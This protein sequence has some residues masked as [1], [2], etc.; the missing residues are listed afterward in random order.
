MKAKTREQLITEIVQL[1]ARVTMLEQSL[2]R[3]ETDHAESKESEKRYRTVFDNTGAGTFVK[4]AD[5]TI[6]MVNQEFEGLTGYTKKA[7]EGRMKW[8][9]FFHP[10]D[11]PRLIMYHA[12][13]RKDQSAPKE[14]ECRISQRTGVIKEVFLKLDLIPGTGQTIGSIVDLSPLKQAQ[15]EIDESRA[16][17]KAIVEGFE[18]LLYVCDA[19]FRLA[20]VNPQGR[21]LAG[22]SAAGE[23][24]YQA[25]H[26]RDAPCLFC[27]QDQVLSGQTVR[28]EMINPKDRRW[29][30]STNSPIHHMDGSVSLLAMVT[31]INDRKQA[32]AALRAAEIQT[33]NENIFLRSRISKRHRLGK[34]VGKSPAMQKVYEQIISAAASD[35]TVIIYGEPGTGKELVAR[36]IH[37][38]SDRQSHQFVPVHCGAIPENLIE[39]EFFGYKKGAFSGADSDRAGYFDFADN[40]TMFLDEIGEI[41]LHM[42]VKLLRV[43]EGTGFTPMGS[44]QVKYPN[45]RIISATN[46]DLHQRIANRRMREDFYYRIHIL[47]IQLPP[48]RERKADLPLLIDHFFKIYGGKQTPPPLTRKMMNRLTQYHWP[49]NI[50]ELQNVIIRYCSLQVLELGSVVPDLLSLNSDTPD[51]NEEERSEQARDLKSLLAVHERRL[52]VQALDQNQW[53]RGKAAEHLKIDRKTLFS[54]MKRYGLR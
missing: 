16:L 20:Y 23:I 40:G 1:H 33:R 45:V 52:I 11:R 6:S 39:S 51:K 24:C 26:K 42:Q 30:H 38:L 14:L 44:S 18:G 53:H 7:I 32:E 47:P 21:R 19:D 27:V 48:L 37:D 49:G 29:Y 3:Y 46:R 43:I 31:D 25:I 22:G 2:R 13:R 17:F 15:R 36:A 28:I 54:K 41:S 12:Q 4:E 5:M 10:D 50:R 9:D 8:T 34:I 35:A